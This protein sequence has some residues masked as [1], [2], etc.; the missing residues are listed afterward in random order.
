[1][2]RFTIP[3]KTKPG[4]TEAMKRKTK[5]DRKIERKQIDELRLQEDKLKGRKG[6]KEIKQLSQFPVDVS[7]PATGSNSLIGPIWIGEFMEEIRF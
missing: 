7:E 6:K 2:L 4:S 3:F 1:M 5:Q